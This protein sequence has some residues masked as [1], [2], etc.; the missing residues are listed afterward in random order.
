MKYLDGLGYHSH[1]DYTYIKQLINL[2]CKNYDIKTDQPYDWQVEDTD[3]DATPKGHSSNSSIDGRSDN[4]P[5]KSTVGDKLEQV[6]KQ[7]NGTLSMNEG[8]KKAQM[9]NGN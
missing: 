3:L 2:A 7:I 1:V 9:R 5:H 4:S 6:V 8:G